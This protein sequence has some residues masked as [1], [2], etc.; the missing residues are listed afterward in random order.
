MYYDVKTRTHFDDNHPQWPLKANGEPYKVLTKKAC[1]EKVDIE[2]APSLLNIACY[3]SVWRMRARAFRDG[4]E[5]G[6][7]SARS[8]AGSTVEDALKESSRRKPEGRDWTADMESEEFKQMMTSLAADG[9]YNEVH[10]MLSCTINRHG[11]VVRLVECGGDIYGVTHDYAYMDCDLKQFFTIDINITSA[12]KKED[13]LVLP[14]VGAGLPQYGVDSR[15]LFYYDLGGHIVVSCKKD[16][17]DAVARK[18][19]LDDTEVKRSASILETS[20]NLDILVQG[21]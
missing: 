1:E 7:S 20:R 15:V 3:S 14:F 9:N 11:R 21:G 19:G 6:F 17:T 2:L 5:A 12:P 13:S 18:Y 16:G 10:S 8:D 4:V